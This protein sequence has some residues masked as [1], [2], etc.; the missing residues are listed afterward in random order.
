MGK[1]KRGILGGFQGKVGTVIGSRWKGVNVIRAVPENVRD[2]NT[3]KQLTQ[4]M[5]F[6]LI[7]DLMKKARPF[8]RKGFEVASGANYSASNAALSYNIKYAITGEYP[9]IEVDLA[10][11][12]FAMGSLLGADGA[13]VASDTPHEISFNWGNNSGRANAKANDQMQ[14][15][16]CKK[17]D[18]L[19][20][21][22]MSKMLLCGCV[23][24]WKKSSKPS[25]IC[26]RYGLKKW[27]A[28]YSREVHFLKSC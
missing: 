12:R 20:F 5:R 26:T 13:Q 4:R 11:V 8:V 2:A 24:L 16:A 22:Q 18:L 25:R 10:E 21:I 7:S 27:S 19:N 9:D 14:V 3:I 1:I 17:V 23:I 6:R 28:I 15:Y